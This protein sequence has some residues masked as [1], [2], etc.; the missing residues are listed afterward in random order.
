MPNFSTH[1]MA[2]LFTM[3]LVVGASMYYGQDIVRTGLVCAG[4]LLSTFLLSPDLDLATS[5]IS[6]DWGPL[7]LLT[8]PYSMIF[9]HGQTS[10]KPILGTLTRYGYMVT[11]IAILT[12]LLGQFLRFTIYDEWELVKT[13]WMYIEYLFMGSVVADLVHLTLD[14]LITDGELRIR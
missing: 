1:T 7:R 13:N 2:N 3:S 12:T 6:H 9:K 14:F 10:H 5:H 4:L 8:V 11:V